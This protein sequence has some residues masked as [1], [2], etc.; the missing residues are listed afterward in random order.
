MLGHLHPADPSDPNVSD[1]PRGLALQAAQA[2]AGQHQRTDSFA[3]T[4]PL[5]KFGDWWI[6][7]DAADNA[8]VRPSAVG[9]DM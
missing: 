4:Y 1:S 7:A 6:D 9:P 3:P 8:R 2:L 5:T